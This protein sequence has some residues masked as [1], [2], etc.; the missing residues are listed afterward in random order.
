M[1]KGHEG[2]YKCIAAD[3]QEGRSYNVVFIR[4]LARDDDDDDDDGGG[5]VAVMEEEDESESHD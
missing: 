5:G 4:V 3:S 1:S 2:S